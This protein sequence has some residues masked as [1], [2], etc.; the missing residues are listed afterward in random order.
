MCIRN[1]I[2]ELISTA[3]EAPPLCYYENQV[4]LHKFQFF[5]QRSSWG[6]AKRSHCCSGVSS[7]TASLSAPG[8]AWLLSLCV[9]ELLNQTDLLGLSGKTLHVTA[10]AAPALPSSPSALL[11]Q[12]INLQLINAK[13]Q[14][15]CGLLLHSLPL[16]SCKLWP[17][18][19]FTGGDFH[20]F[21]V[22]F[23]VFFS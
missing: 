18:S 5:Q 8:V 22:I 9:A 15:M 19:L 10:G 12:Y 20:C 11:C 6:W 13:P 2:Q 23:K 16:L 17:F 7:E 21:M 14:G 1:V 4:F 3:N